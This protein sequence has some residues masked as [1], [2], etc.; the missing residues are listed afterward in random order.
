MQGC[1]GEAYKH[2]NDSS[3]KLEEMHRQ[4]LRVLF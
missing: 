4:L 2:A 3:L 1:N